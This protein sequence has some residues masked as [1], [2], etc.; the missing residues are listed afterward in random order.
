MSCRGRN[1]HLLALLA[2]LP[3]LGLSAHAVAEGAEPTLQ[4]GHADHTGHAATRAWGDLMLFPALT[5]S[6]RSAEVSGLRQKELLPEINIFYSVER[7]RLRFLAEYLASRDEHEMER[8]ALGWVLHPTTTAWLGRFHS[9]LGFWNSEHH[10][11]A[12]MQT[13]IS[14]PGILAFE[15]EGGVLPTHVTGV[16]VEGTFDRDDGAI[17]YALGFG[18]GP[19]FEK[20]LKPLD[21][22][23]PEG[24]GRPTG[25]ARISRAS[26]RYGELGAFAAY[27]HIPIAG[28]P[29]EASVQTIA[30]LFYVVGIDELRLLAEFFYVGNRIED[31]AAARTS[32]FTAG[33]LQGE[34][35]LRPWT[36]FARIEGTHDAE[37]DEYLDLNPH[38]VV[39]RA[40]AGARRELSDHQALKI[41]VSNSERQDD[42]GFTQVSVQW[43]MIF[44]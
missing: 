42:T 9:P 14:R 30:G 8:F 5:A 32:R 15:D 25:I 29:I 19:V 23:D 35:A 40:M 28:R 2:A 20:E 6:H 44:P 7:A 39:A 27:A 18:R 10:H 36:L 26:D 33:Y 11:G 4:A 24:G 12:F 34:Y 21:V 43:S 41:E 37:G 3:L 16:L 17:N 38:Y 1:T 22:L 31:G 13:T